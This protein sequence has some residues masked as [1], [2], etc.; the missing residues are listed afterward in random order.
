MFGPS[1]GAL[2]WLVVRGQLAR[3]GAAGPGRRAEGVA[4]DITEQQ[5]V[6]RQLRQ[7][8]ERMTLTRTALGLGTWETDRGHRQ[9]HW[10][11]QMFRLRGIESPARVITRPEIAACLHPDERGPVMAAQAVRL[12]DGQPWH[13]EF[14]VLRPDG[15]VRWI[16]SHSVPVYDEQG[17]EDRRIGVNWDS[18]EAHVAAAAPRQRLIC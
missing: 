11:T 5:L 16:T 4:I 13:T 17:V 9:I 6:L 7:T 3:G 8:V 14:R 2:R 1:D 18:T 10:D 12:L 15:Q